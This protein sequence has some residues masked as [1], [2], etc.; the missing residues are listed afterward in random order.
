MKKS[1]SVLMIGETLLVSACSEH[2][3]CDFTYC[4]ATQS[5][6]TMATCS[7]KEPIHF[8]VNSNVLDM[9]DKENLDKVA[10]YL[11]KHSH[12]KIQ[13]MGYTD[14][15]GSAAYNKKLSEQ[16]AQ[17]A[18]NYLISMGIDAH[19]ISTRGMGATD[20]IASNETADGRAQNRRIEIKY[21]E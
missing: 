17:S 16:R 12:K 1:F 7:G 4:P 2:R 9:K 15:T 14:S 13:I 10:R 11:R 21:W 5:N 8:S 18:A 19:R 3:S 20:F 6:G